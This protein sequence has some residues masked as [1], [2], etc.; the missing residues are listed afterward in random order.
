MPHLRSRRGQ[1]AAAGG[2]LVALVLVP[3]APAGIPIVAAALA[4]VPA[5]LF[6][7]S[8]SPTGRPDGGEGPA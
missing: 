1:V 3:L 2:A 5:V 6:A 8:P 7:P 4:V